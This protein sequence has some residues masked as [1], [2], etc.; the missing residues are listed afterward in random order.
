MAGSRDAVRMDDTEVAAFLA[1]QVKVQVASLGHDGFPH[2]TTLF[3]VLEEGRIAFWTYARSQKVRNLERDDRVAC[4]VEDG[5]EYAELRG[6]SVRG[7]AE[8]VRDRAAV[9]RI[10]SAVVVAMT[11]VGS[12]D[13]LGDLGRAEVERQAG[14]RVAVVVHPD[15]VASWDH[16]KPTTRG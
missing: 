7:R 8:I 4:L 12:L 10:G 6:V 3:Y 1:S 11:G 14:K 16:G 15:H 13:D 2:L 5:T 9:E